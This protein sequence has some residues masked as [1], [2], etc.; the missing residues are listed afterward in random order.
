M[1]A[2]KL[3]IGGKWIESDSGET[4]K[5]INPATEDTVAVC[6]KGNKQDV[7]AAIEAAERAFGWA[8]TPGP[9][10]GQILF[11]VAELLK[12]NKEALARLE[13]QEMGK[14]LEES[15]GDVQEAIDAFEY[16]AGEGRRLFGRTTT[17]ELKDKFAMSVRRPFG[18]VGIITPWNFPIAIPA[19]KLAP[20]LVCGNTVVFKPSS[21]TPLCAIELVKILEQAGVPPGVVNLVTG[22]G[23]DV[24]T[25]IV[26]S[27]RVRGIS[28]TGNRETGLWITQNAGIKR[29]GL[30]L[31]GKNCI[32]IM[33]DAD[34]DLA[35]DGVIW[36]GFGTTGQRC[37][38]TSRIIIS[39]KIKEK[40]KKELVSRVKKLKVGNGLTKVDMGPLVNKSALDKTSRYVT[41]GVKEGAQLLCGGKQI[42]GK[43]FFHEPTIFE[44]HPDMEIAQE[45]IFGPVVTL[46]GFSRL[47]EAIKIANSTQYGLSSS[48]YTKDIKTAFK[49]IERLETGITYVNAPTIGAEV[50]LPFGGVKQSGTTRESGW[51][52]LEEFSDEQ[53]GYMD[54]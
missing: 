42:K 26:K 51:T 12:K 34:L 24:G 13:T 7:K 43:G 4:F 49:A 11:K 36:G 29:V 16:F 54:Y 23:G 31:G 14:I 52:G 21:D 25:E 18:V 37:T 27:K 10:R 41:I 33:D 2:E 48:I 30:E 32:V 46:L 28:F 53:A 19:W 22:G 47:E 50:H 15:R 3:Y 8:E 39:E 45:E 44:G 9:K 6:Q 1:P 5:S 38:A 20:A 35:L 17:S 40:F